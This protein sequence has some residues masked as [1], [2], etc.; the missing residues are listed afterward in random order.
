MKQEYSLLKA[1]S[2]VF[3]VFLTAG[4]LVACGKNE[5]R[6]AETGISRSA[7]IWSPLS[8]EN[9]NSDS[10]GIGK[11]IP[12]DYDAIADQARSIISDHQYSTAVS[13]LQDGAQNGHVMS[14]RYLGVCLVMLDREVEGA[15]WIRKAAEAGD[16]V[17][18]FNMAKCYNYGCGVKANIE[19]VN[20]WAQKAV[21]NGWEGALVA[22]TWGGRNFRLE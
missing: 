14:Q 6:S 15:S 17:S 12:K 5:S 4:L 7:G 13:M 2:R 10:V 18:Q 11:S 3:A 16:V 20:F 1:F 21:D 8:A 9:G 19:E 22:M